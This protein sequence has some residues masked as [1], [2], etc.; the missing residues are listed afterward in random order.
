M[1][2]RDTEMVLVPRR[3]SEVTEIR[4]DRLSY[5]EVFSPM[6]DNEDR[7]YFSENSAVS[8]DPVS[9]GEWARKKALSLAESTEPAEEDHQ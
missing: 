8:N 7:M 9:T 3:I 5:I 1:G 4:R 2:G 6:Y